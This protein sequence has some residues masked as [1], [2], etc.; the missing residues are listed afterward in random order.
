MPIRFIAELLGR[1]ICLA[2]DLCTTALDRVAFLA[3][4]PI[5]DSLIDVAVPGEA[6]DYGAYEARAGL[7]AYSLATQAK[8]EDGTAK[9][10][11]VHRLVHDFARRAMTAERR[12]E[13]LREAL[14]WIN[15]AFV[16]DPWDVRTWPV[17][18]PLAPHALAVAHRADE[19]GIAEPTVQLFGTTG[20]LFHA[21]ARYAEAEPLLPRAM[22]IDE[23]NFGPDH[24]QV[25]TGLN[26]IVE[27]LRDTNRLAEAEP[28]FRRALKIDETSFGSDHPNVAIRLNNLASLLR[29]TNHIVE[30]ERLMRRAL[31]VDEANLGPDHPNAARD[32]NNLAELLRTV[33]VRSV[34]VAHIRRQIS[35]R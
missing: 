3:P 17:L 7:Y 25:A 35:P 10:F 34:G 5:P 13:A 31:A 33:L 26:N 18:D 2:S 16:G 11:V 12:G 14:E 19:I 28:L 32:L 20:L 9:G 8:G 1:Q 6:P 21:K 30:A 15:P 4:D 29:A 22:A 27:L 23:E 24:T